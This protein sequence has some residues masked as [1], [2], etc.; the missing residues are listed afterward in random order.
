MIGNIKWY[1]KEKGYGFISGEDEKEYFVHYSEAPET[2][3][4][5]NEEDNIKVEFE[6][7]EGRDGRTQAS[8]VKFANSD[9]SEDSK[10]SDDSDDSEEL[11]AA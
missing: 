3:E 10:E 7:K 4:T 1:N 5:C 8:A 11:L 6:L 2:L 9:D